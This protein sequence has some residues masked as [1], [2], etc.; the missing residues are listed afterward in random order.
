MVHK[1]YCHIVTSNQPSTTLP[2]T[3]YH[4]KL[5]VPRAQAKS[6]DIFSYK[7]SANKFQ[8]NERI[9]NLEW[10][11]KKLLIHGK[12][13]LSLPIRRIFLRHKTLSFKFHQYDERFLLVFSSEV[14]RRHAFNHRCTTVS[15]HT[16]KNYIFNKMYFSVLFPSNL[17]PDVC[18][19]W[20]CII[21]S[22]WRKEKC[23][24]NS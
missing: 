9:Y 22:K 3:V 18:T 16:W 21:F 15:F 12:Q 20:A 10:S 2:L 1:L 4:V 24:R 13:I 23:N 19:R 14:T 7:S 5:I 17:K 11:Q 8:L 6:V